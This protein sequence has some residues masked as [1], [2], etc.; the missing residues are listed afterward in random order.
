MLGRAFSAMAV[1]LGLPCFCKSKMHW[2]SKLD[3]SVPVT[4]AHGKLLIWDEKS[5][6]HMD[7]G[8]APPNS[9][10]LSLC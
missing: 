9:P 5:S 4:S 10:S 1:S 6:V 7:L 2:L 8:R 3:I